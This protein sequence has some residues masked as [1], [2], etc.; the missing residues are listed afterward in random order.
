M[1]SISLLIFWFHAYTRVFTLGSKTL[2]Y[3]GVL[4][5]FFMAYIKLFQTTVIHMNK[6]ATFLVDPWHCSNDQFSF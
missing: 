2:F 5:L 6:I 3:F 1:S 4:K